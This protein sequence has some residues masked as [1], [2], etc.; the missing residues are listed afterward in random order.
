M[1]DK[2]WT[3]FMA[4]H[5]L[6]SMERSCMN[7]E[8]YEMRFV[9]KDG[10]KVEFHSSRAEV[11]AKYGEKPKYASVTLFEQMAMAWYADN[12]DK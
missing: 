5:N 4:D 1:N 3:I 7:D 8:H 11:A 10:K 6:R 2:I 9:T 12:F